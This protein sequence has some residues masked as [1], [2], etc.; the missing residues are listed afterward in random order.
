M[1]PEEAFAS[2]PSGLRDPL[3]FEYQNIVQNYME[4]RWSPAELSGGKFCE[5]VYTI[6]DG[7][8]KGKYLNKPSKPRDFVA[9]C[10]K[11]EN[12][13]H[14]PRSFQILIPRILPALYEVRNNRGVGHAGGDVDPNQM[15]G[16]VVISICNWV[17]AEMVR[18]FHGLSVQDAQ[19]LVENLTER[20][21]PIVWHG[22]EMRRVLDPNLPLKDQLLL[23]I[24][25]STA[26]VSTSDLQ[27]WTGYANKTYFRRILR[28]LHTD[29]LVELSKDESMVEI[30]P[31][32]SNYIA[33]FMSK[34]MMGTL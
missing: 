15:D 22:D 26:K 25:S 11:L 3:L 30:L 5:I 32:G 9:A 29:R 7:H 10:R 4:R 16:T 27:D 2:V 8:A 12:N 18:V 23:L 20:R 1:D 24:A 21:L 6:I 31:P 14:V 13:N 34:Q 33:G 28:G 19:G 17:M